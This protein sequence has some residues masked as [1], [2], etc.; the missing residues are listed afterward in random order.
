MLMTKKKTTGR[1]KPNRS[2][3]GP[4]R[5]KMV[6]EFG[7]LIK[8]IR[9]EEELTT[10]ELAA[11]SGVPQSTV[12]RYEVG[13]REPRIFNLVRMARALNAVDRISEFLV[14]SA[15]ILPKPIRPV[16]NN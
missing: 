11:L 2:A 6:V 10:R 8:K 14:Q 15:A 12:M 5:R 16:D 1:A 4:E 9:E 13:D 3:Y 7:R